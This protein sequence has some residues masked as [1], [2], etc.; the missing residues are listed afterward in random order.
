MSSSVSDPSEAIMSSP[1]ARQHHPTVEMEPALRQRSITF[2]FPDPSSL[3]SAEAAVSA[4]VADGSTCLVLHL[5]IRC[6]VDYLLL[7]VTEEET[8]APGV[9][10]RYDAPALG[11]AAFM[12]E[13][14]TPSLEFTVLLGLRDHPLTNLLASTIAHRIRRH[15]ENRS[16]LMGLSVVQTA[17]KLR[18]GRAKKAFLD[19]TASNILE[20][21]GGAP[22]TPK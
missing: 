21:A 16:L 19:Y 13:E 1:A 15:G 7:F 5:S 20:I 6:F 18:S 12:Y 8:C 11:P 17:K 14:E 10:L 9:L 22:P 4:E 2:C 3:P